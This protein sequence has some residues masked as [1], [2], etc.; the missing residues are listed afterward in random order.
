MLINTYTYS[1]EPAVLNHC[2]RE[3]VIAAYNN[4]GQIQLRISAF[5][6]ND[7]KIPVTFMQP[8]RVN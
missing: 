3:Y 6:N 2:D 7:T 5:E 4:N 1:W 8:N